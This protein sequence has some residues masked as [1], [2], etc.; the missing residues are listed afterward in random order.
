MT[1]RDATGS[2]DSYNKYVYMRTQH[3]YLSSINRIPFFCLL[4]LFA[5]LID[6]KYFHVGAY[7][8]TDILEFIAICDCCEGNS[9]ANSLYDE[10]MGMYTVVQKLGDSSCMRGVTAWAFVELA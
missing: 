5:V 7:M 10:Y 6:W 2:S 3:L 9:N 8:S 4:S 1:S